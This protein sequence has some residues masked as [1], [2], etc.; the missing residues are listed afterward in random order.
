MWNPPSLSVIPTQADLPFEKKSRNW[1]NPKGFWRRRAL[2]LIALPPITACCNLG[3]GQCFAKQI[4]ETKTT[5][6]AIQGILMT[7]PNMVRAEAQLTQSAISLTKNC[8]LPLFTLSD[9]PG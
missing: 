9:S 5:M 6:M 8:G 7:P 4:D 2:P 3:S 1:A